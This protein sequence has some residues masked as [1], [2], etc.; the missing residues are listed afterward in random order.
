MYI[1][2]RVSMIVRSHYFH[3]NIFK[4][5][6]KMTQVSESRPLS[7]L[8]QRPAGSVA[9]VP[10]DFVGAV[11]KK[12]LC[13]GSDYPGTSY[14]LG[15]CVNDAVEFGYVLK[16]IYGYDVSYMVDSEFKKASHFSLPS[17]EADPELYS[18]IAAGFAAGTKKETI[19]GAI[20]YFLAETGT[21][22]M[23]LYLSGHGAQT[24]DTNGDEADGK[25]EYYL[26][27]D[28]L[29]IVDDEWN[30]LF[31][32]GLSSAKN[33]NE[34]RTLRVFFDACHSG[35]MIDLPY[36]YNANGEVVS[37][38]GSSISE[39]PSGLNVIAVTA[40]PDSTTTSEGYRGGI[41]TTLLQDCFKNTPKITIGQFLDLV[42]S[43]K[44]AIHVSMNRQFSRDSQL[45]GTLSVDSSRAV[46]AATNQRFAPSTPA[47]SATLSSRGP[48][49]RE[50]RPTRNFDPL[51][52][53]MA[54]VARSAPSNPAQAPSANRA[55]LETRTIAHSAISVTPA[56]SVPP[57]T[58]A[59][60]STVPASNAPP[61]RPAPPVIRSSALPASSAPLAS[62]IP[63]ITRSAALPASSAPLASAIPP[64]TRSAA[65]PASS[66]PLASA[67]P[68]PPIA[69]E[70][71]RSHQAPRQANSM[72]SISMNAQEAA[73]RE[74]PI[75]IRQL[76]RQVPSADT[77]V[78][79][80]ARA[81]TP[82]AVVTPVP[83][84]RSIQRPVISVQRDS[85][86]TATPITSTVTGVDDVESARQMTVNVQSRPITLV[87]TLVRNPINSAPVTVSTITARDIH[88]MNA[89]ARTP[90]NIQ[91]SDDGTT[92]RSRGT[93]ARSTVSMLGR[94]I[95]A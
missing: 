80:P 13:I 3:I 93:I 82:I 58:S 21:N 7:R 89:A 68:P 46:P 76:S 41:V 9:S 91:E 61:A 35:S 33:G 1:I 79:V 85:Q 88:Q 84:T 52:G 40:C 25:D 67:I 83:N 23:A 42:K 29:G 92:G 62:A 77:G 57:Q 55:A 66:A 59:A 50:T 90:V 34:P 51:A 65:L 54:D 8:V 43:K 16:S 69:G 10:R 5:N 95:R 32:S 94:Y 48:P 26:T 4:I 78:S 60:R 49:T 56:T 74:Q 75:A 19:L 73:P 18:R 70:T 2:S 30:S 17:R 14:S 44:S 27:G 20:R 63:P 6:I 64:I 11:R 72:S 71:A 12:A 31:K 47:M 28:G 45:F 38:A 22:E 37:V 86:T 39:W 36:C 81:A 87:P 53:V 15:E 24:K